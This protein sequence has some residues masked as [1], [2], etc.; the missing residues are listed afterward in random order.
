MHTLALRRCTRDV[1]LIRWRGR[2]LRF[3]GRVGQR[4]TGSTNRDGSDPAS[5]GPGTGSGAGVFVHTCPPPPGVAPDP[6]I[7]RGKATERRQERGGST[8]RSGLLISTLA[9]EVAHPFALEPTLALE[10]VRAALSYRL[11][12]KCMY[13]WF[14]ISRLWARQLLS[15]TAS[16]WTSPTRPTGRP[17]TDG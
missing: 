5:R 11:D 3:R 7:P 13:Q 10:Q 14:A 9:T 17:P 6:S 2:I 16:R 4:R 15:S 1:R 8:N 12:S